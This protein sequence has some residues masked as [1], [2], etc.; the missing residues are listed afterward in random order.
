MYGYFDLADK[1][2]RYFTLSRDE[3]RAM[4]VVILAATFIISFKEW[5]PGD[6]FDFGYGI[7][8]FIIFLIIAGI[9]V[10]VH[11]AAQRIA[12]LHAGHRT[13]FRIWWFGI[14]F[15]L[16][17]VIITRGMFWLILPGGILLHHMATH[18][19]GY[20]RYGTNTM[21]LAMVSLSGSLANIILATII[22]T[23]EIWFGFPISQIYFLDRLVFFN[24][25]YALFNLLPIPPLDGFNVLYYSR[26]T[27]AFIFGS[28]AGYFLLIL[29]AGVFSFVYALLIGIAVWL[30]FMLIFE[31]DWWKTI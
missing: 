30:L 13:E 26:L 11:I 10:F 14:I 24:W 5:G 7:S 25:V 31:F 22:K 21:T 16:I 17:L 6:V 23:P 4:I 19:L 28:V 8:R 15:G 9:T 20:F 27:Y 3:L 12:G 2:K 29:A 1:I 18:R